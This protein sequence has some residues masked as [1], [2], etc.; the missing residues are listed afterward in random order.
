MTLNWLV[1]LS[2]QAHAH[3]SPAFQKEMKQLAFYFAESQCLQLQML[4]P[5]EGI[6]P[7][8]LHSH[9]SKVQLRTG[10]GSNLSPLPAR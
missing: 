9:P 1:L 4:H 6:A 8:G 3:S 5:T 10:L 2:A 7:A